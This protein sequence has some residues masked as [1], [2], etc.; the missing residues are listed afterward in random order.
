M[1][2][3]HLPPKSSNIK[4]H[5][6]WQRLK[7]IFAVGAFSLVV[8]M[9]GAAMVIGWIWPRYAEG[10]TWITT[11]NRPALSKL[12]LEDRVRDEISARIF[13][14]YSGLVNAGSANYF[15]QKIGDAAVVGSD[16]WM[17]LY[18]PDYDGSYKS[19]YVITP[20]GAVYQ[21]EAGLFDKYSG[22]LYLK[23]KGGPF[24]VVSFG[25]NPAAL[26][27]IF[28]YQGSNW[29]H[30]QVQYP[31]LGAALPH[32]DS[33]PAIF[34][35]VDG[36]F[37]AGAV[38][39]NS[40]GRVVGILKEGNLLVPGEYITRIMPKVLSQSAV[41]Y[42][43]LGADGWFSGEQPLVSGKQ[44]VIGF[45]VSRVWASGSLLRRGDVILEIDGRVVSAD[46]LWYI[47]SGKQTVRLKILRNGKNLEIVAKITETNK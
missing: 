11:Y 38:A 39:I 43:S 3:P 45:S 27:D 26:D 4:T 28:I 5:R 19:L 37:T 20:D 7:V 17:V 40:Q 9:C 46:N 29:H 21:P 15:K 41:V 23:I 13:S 44:T 12:Q 24:K 25:D 6:M 31:V 10:D 16:G 1:Q 30:D 2:P 42:P 34:Y 32:M 8:G 14:V 18:K 47:I 35:P 33:A 22:L 36:N